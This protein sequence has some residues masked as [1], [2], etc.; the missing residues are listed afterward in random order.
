MLVPSPPD[1]TWLV[2]PPVRR[3]SPLPRVWRRL[4]KYFFVSGC[5]SS[6]I[7]FLPSLEMR[8]EPNKRPALILSGMA[9]MDKRPN[10]AVPRRTTTASELLRGISAIGSTG[11][12]RL[13]KAMHF[14]SMGKRV[15]RKTKFIG[16]PILSPRRLPQPLRAIFA[17]VSRS[18]TVRLNTGAFPVESLSA[19]K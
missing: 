14:Y 2:S 11:H 10:T 13:T 12:Q 6:R 7:Q 8:S 1:R 9:R 18:V 17:Q 3:S 5:W 16:S 19:A 15:R 4:T